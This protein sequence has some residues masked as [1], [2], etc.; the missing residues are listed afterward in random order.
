TGEIERIPVCPYCKARQIT[1]TYYSDYDLAKII[2]KKAAGK[3]ITAEE[4]HR[5][6]RAWKV[7]SLLANF[8]KT[9]LVVLS[10]Y[11]VGADTASRI[12][13]NMIDEENL[14]RQIYEAERL[15][16]TT[17]GFWD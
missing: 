6:S 16:V 4:N 14:Y 13:K 5:F 2:Q 3:K 10:G 7:A 15:Y 8:G 1:S 17:R 12:L 11:G 9:A